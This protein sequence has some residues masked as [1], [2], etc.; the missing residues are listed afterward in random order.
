MSTDTHTSASAWSPG[1]E[2]LIE[3]ITTGLEGLPDP[4]V[5]MV[6][7]FTRYLRARYRLPL[8][9]VGSREALLAC[10]GKWQTGTEE[11]AALDAYIQ[12]AREMPDERL[13]A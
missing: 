3:Q 7:D 5:R 9:P 8:H 4:I 13:F 2:A 10:W 6:L 11:R 12:T 1:S